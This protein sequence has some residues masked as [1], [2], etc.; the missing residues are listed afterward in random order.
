MKYALLSVAIVLTIIFIVVRIKK[1]GLLGLFTKTTASLAFVATALVGAYSAGLKLVSLFV[2]L[3]LIFGLIGDIVLDL[4][5]IYKSQQ[6]QYLNAGMLSFGLGHIM[7]MVATILYSNN[8]FFKDINTFY[9]ILVGFGFAGIV[10]VLIAILAKPVLKIDFGNFKYQSLA[11]TFIL[12][13]MS[14]FSVIVGFFSPIFLIFAL[15]I[16]FIFISDL[17]LS[18]QYFGGKQDSKLLTILNHAIY[19][20]GQIAIA[21]SLF[22]I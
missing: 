7:Y 22:Y 9:I 3:G 18:L 4:K 1:G 12:S 14:A 16:I 6:S 20:I 19:Y 10:T 2:L 5:I 8:L 11:Y 15:G 21:F 17:I 13:F